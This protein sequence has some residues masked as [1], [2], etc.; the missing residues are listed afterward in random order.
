MLPQNTIPESIL[1]SGFRD[2]EDMTG[3]MHHGVWLWDRPLT[4]FEGAKGDDLLLLDTPS[5]VLKP[6]WREQ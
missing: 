3:F 1:E 6:L 2:G 5:D 4:I